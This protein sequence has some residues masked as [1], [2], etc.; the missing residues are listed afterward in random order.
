MTSIGTSREPILPQKVRMIA[1]LVVEYATDIQMDSSKAYFTINS[2]GVEKRY[3]LELNEEGNFTF[4][5]ANKIN[6]KYQDKIIDNII[7]TKAS[8]IKSF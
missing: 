5:Q 4:A 6:Y 3:E 2:K 8:I 1:S 7:C